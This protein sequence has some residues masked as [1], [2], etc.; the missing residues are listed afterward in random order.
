MYISII[1]S[2]EHLT[3]FV[4]FLQIDK[5]I[6][7]YLI[8]PICYRGSLGCTFK[9]KMNF[10]CKI[11]V[12]FIILPWF[13]YLVSA[14]LQNSFAEKLLLSNSNSKIFIQIYTKS[15]FRKKRFEINFFVRQ[16]ASKFAIFIEKE[17]PLSFFRFS[18]RA[19]L[20]F[21]LWMPSSM[22]HKPK[23]S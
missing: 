1:W 21:P 8:L 22:W 7:N 13:S 9:E 10:L 19:T 12:V 20:S 2:Y 17:N 4:H 14:T 6:N 23:H 16:N 15:L 5:K 3:Y 11:V 18:F